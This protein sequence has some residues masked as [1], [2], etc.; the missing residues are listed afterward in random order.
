MLIN[1]DSLI[2]IPLIVKLDTLPLHVVCSS[3][4]KQVLNLNSAVWNRL[5]AHVCESETQ[6]V[7]TVFDIIVRTSIPFCCV[8]KPNPYLVPRLILQLYSV[9]IRLV[10]I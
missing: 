5:P 6:Y 3:P 9:Q 2:E 1:T 10:V 4:G 8:N 7:V